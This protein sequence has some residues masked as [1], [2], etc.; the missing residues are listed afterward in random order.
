VGAG[1]TKTLDFSKTFASFH[2]PIGSWVSGSGGKWI[3]HGFRGA[4]GALRRKLHRVGC[5]FLRLELKDSR[6][7]DQDR[8]NNEKCHAP[9][10]F[11]GCAGGVGEGRKNHW[12]HKPIPNDIVRLRHDKRASNERMETTKNDEPKELVVAVVIFPGIGEAD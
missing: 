3:R 4:C 10:H 12:Q 8:R 11:N 1:A 6:K 7:P 2:L 9:R 5:Q